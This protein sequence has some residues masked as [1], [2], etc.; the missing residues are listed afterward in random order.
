MVSSLSSNFALTTDSNGRL[1][2]TG[3]SGSGIDTQKAVEALV[4]AKRVPIDR[5]ETK[6]ETTGTQIAALKEYQTLMRDFRTAVDGLRG[7]VT[8]DKSGDAFD[9]K[10]VYLQTSRVDGKTASTA[11]NLVGITATNNAEVGARSVEILRV[12][13]QAKVGTGVANSATADLGTAFG[14]AAGSISG[15][16]DIVNGDGAATT[17]TVAGTDTLQSLRDKIN[18]ANTGTAKTGVT[19]SI[20]SVTTGQNYLVLTN[21]A[22]GKAIELDNE[23]G[24]VLSGLGISSDGGSTFSNVLQEP[25]T[26]RLAVDGLKDPS[27]YESLRFAN[28]SASVKSL[29]STAPDTGSFTLSTGLGTVAIN[30]NST[31]DSLNDIAARINADAGAIGVEA[32]IM[33]DGGGK[34]LVLTDTNGG[35]LGVIDNDGLMASLGVDND[36]VVERSSNTISDLFTGMTLNLFQAEEGTKINLQVERNLNA[37]KDQVYDFLDAYNAMRRFY[38]EQNLT[39]ADGSKSEDAGPLFGNSALKDMN[40]MLR[41]TVNGDVA[42]LGIDFSA[43]S[44][45]GIT[46]APTATLTDPLDRETLVIDESKFDEVLLNKPDDVRNLFSFRFSSDNPDVTLVN[47][48]ANTSY[49]NGGYNLEVTV[50][51]GVITS[52]KLDGQDVEVNG[53]TLTV[54][55][56]SAAGLK[57]YYRPGDDGTTTSQLN[58]TSGI[59]SQMYF[60]ADKALTAKT[61]TIEAQLGVFESRNSAAELQ[62]D[63]MELRLDLYKDRITAKFLRMEEALSRMESIMEALKAQIDAQS[64]NSDK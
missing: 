57:L 16:F 34:R 43:L 54:T 11:T 55:S 59:A 48:G 2:V 49:K 24:G 27:R 38:N 15:S 23:T 35:K 28:A 33:D 31:T 51:G 58:I 46:I 53:T 29:V 37:V 14:G 45:I 44:A 4:A 18:N 10:N 30:F 60:A 42:G 36:L 13:T 9:A 47:F 52:A 8:F 12:A 41:D 20:V 5:L 50:A 61:G 22:T 39:G 62:I 63:R 19:A 32:T 3:L 21:D 25:Q 64:S 1:T 17:I 40:T 7:K 56:G 26:A 6:I